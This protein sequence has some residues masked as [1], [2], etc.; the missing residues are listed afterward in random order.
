[1]S[2]G[3]Y[4]NIA[5]LKLCSGVYDCIAHQK[6]CPCERMVV[7]LIRRCVLT[8]VW[9]YCRLENESLEGCVLVRVRRYR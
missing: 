6:T 4:D 9:Q 8:C 1:M 2:L 7:L 5:D 3:L